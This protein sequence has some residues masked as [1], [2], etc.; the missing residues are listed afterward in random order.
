MNAC[1]DVLVVNRD[2]WER[3]RSS[4]LPFFLSF[5]LPYPFRPGNSRPELWNGV[6]R[7][8][9]KDDYEAFNYSY[10]P[11]GRP[12]R[13]GVSG[14][15]RKPISI[16]RTWHI[17]CTYSRS[18]VL[19]VMAWRWIIARVLTGKRNEEHEIFLTLYGVAMSGGERARREWIEKRERGRTVYTLYSA[20]I[21]FRPFPKVNV[22][23]TDGNRYEYALNIERCL[24]KLYWL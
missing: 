7:T 21:G 11:T 24:K 18:L 13:H 20:Y 14:I 6:Q 1:M 3:E 23:N 16:L 9:K 8:K 17:Y 19:G 4:S 12:G 15:S 2:E 5:I 10:I 22:C